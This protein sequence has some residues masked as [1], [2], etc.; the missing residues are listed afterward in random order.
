L[1]LVLQ[2]C[3]LPENH[4]Q[5]IY[6]IE[7]P[8][9]AIQPLSMSD[10]EG[11]IHLIYYQGDPASGNLF[12]CRFDE[13]SRKLSDPI[14]VNGKDSSAIAVGTIRGAQMAIGR[15]DLVHVIWN[16][17]SAATLAVHDSAMVTP[18]LYARM[19]DDKKHF[20]PE[21]NLIQT[22]WG[23]D[24]GSAIATDEKGNIYVSWHA[25]GN[26]P[27]EENRR[28][29]LRKSEDDG[30][31]FSDELAIND[32]LVGACGCC[33][34]HL[35]SDNNGH[36]LA[37]YRSA[38]ER[39]HRDIHLIDFDD[40]NTLSE[41]VIDKWELEA[42]PMSSI[43]SG[44]SGNMLAFT[45]QTAGE[46]FYQFAKAQ[47][48]VRSPE[49][50]ANGAKHSKIAISDNDHYL[51]AWT[52]GTGWNKGGD[53]AWELRDEAGKLLE[54]GKKDNAIAV[55]SFPAVVA[56]KNNAFYIFN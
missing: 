28:V 45:W 52:E 41:S 3:G 8:E 23:L 51:I 24:G 37:L 15:G 16:A 17:S 42:C 9:G 6:H 12:Y 31:T 55:W 38:G 29:Y 44:R 20:E 26:E 56:G 46:V 53:L 34:M 49:K 18:L 22:H 33:G 27:G 2:Q 4:E 14:R 5:V 36:V 43:S 13:S 11:F 39:K 30:R 35:T 50:Q 54:S 10:T 47:S 40:D 25:T 19:A 48:P 1:F 32:P 21:A 7:L